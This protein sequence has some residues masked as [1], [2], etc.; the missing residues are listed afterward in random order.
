MLPTCYI[1]DL[2]KIDMNNQDLLQLRSKAIKEQ[3]DL[4]EAGGRK[5]RDELETK[6]VSQLI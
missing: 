3:N 5:G 4:Q 2:P 1:L 6:R